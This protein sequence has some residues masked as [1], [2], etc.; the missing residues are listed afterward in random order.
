MSHVGVRLLVPPTFVVDIGGHLHVALQRVD[1]QFVE[2]LVF[3]QRKLPSQRY[4]VPLIVHRVNQ[5]GV[6]VVKLQEENTVC[7]NAAF[8]KLAQL[9]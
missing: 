5:H 1:R 4:K 7:H 9:L 2:M 6:V 8:E 3:L